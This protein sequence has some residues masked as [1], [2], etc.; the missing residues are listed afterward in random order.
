MRQNGDYTGKPERKR[1][2]E[3]F[4]MARILLHSPPNTR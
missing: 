1:G 4:T 2:R 3:P